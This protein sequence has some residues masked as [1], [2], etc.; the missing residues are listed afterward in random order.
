M[1]DKPN[2]R[3]RPLEEKDLETVAMFEGEIAKISFP[4][5]PITDIPFYV[6]KLKQLMANKDAAAFVA[7]S[8]AG[9][10]GWANVSQRQNFITKEKYADFHSIYVAPS[11]R[12]GGVVSALV[13]AVFDH[14]RKQGLDKVVFRTRA[15]NERMKS[16]LAR[17]GFVPTQIYYEKALGDK[18]KSGG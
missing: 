12:G 14:C 16:V 1:T 3:L 9:L 8:D 15:D 4:D 17:V 2:F 18:D 13:N 10:V 11:Q 7:E 5:D 6:K